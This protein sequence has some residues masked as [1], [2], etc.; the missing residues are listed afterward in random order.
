MR[1]ERTKVQNKEMH[2][3]SSVKNFAKVTRFANP[4]AKAGEPL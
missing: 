4:F 2:M 1:N 3:Q